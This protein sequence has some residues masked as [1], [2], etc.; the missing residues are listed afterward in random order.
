MSFDFR[1]LINLVE[2]LLLENVALSKGG[3]QVIKNAEMVAGLAKRVRRDARMNPQN[4]PSGFSAKVEKLPDQNVAEWFLEQLDQI[5]KAGYE[6]VQYSRDG[7]NHAWIAAKYILGAHNWEDITGT[8]SMNL[9]KFYFLK[10]R[11]MLDA[12]HT[13]IPAFKSIREIG[14]YMV[15]H[16]QQALAD[17]DAKMKAAAMKKAVRAFLIVDNDDYKIYTTLNRAANVAMGQ[18]T[19]WCTSSSSYDGHYHNYAKAGML[20]QMFP[21]DPE[22]VELIRVD[23]RKIEG[24]ERY[25]FD[26]GSYNPN[27]MNIADQPPSKQYINEKFPYLYDDIINGLRTKKADIETYIKTAAEDPNLQTSDTKVKEYKIDEEIA[28]LQKFVAAGW[29]TTNKRPKEKPPEETPELPAPDA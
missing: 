22:E 3:Q 13:N 10:N 5:E 23:S 6:G 8:M 14:E 25:Q 2:S 21:Y 24:K 19:T 15:H 26:V 18:G 16:Y 17:Y 28:K 4:F 20:F 7:V 27:F 11:N 1:S 9:G 29:M 12:A